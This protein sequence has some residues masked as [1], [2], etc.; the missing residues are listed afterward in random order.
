MRVL[1]VEDDPKISSFLLKGL[2]EDRHVV[3]HAMD[4]VSAEERAELEAFDAIVLDLILPGRDGWQVCR[5]LRAAGVLTPI[6]M[7]T[8]R[9]AVADRVLGL[10]A[11]ADDYLVKPFAFEE[12]VARLRALERRG[13]SRVRPNLLQEGPL[14][15]DLE[16]HQ[17]RLEGRLLDLTATEYRLL[18][19]LTR[20]AGTIVSREQL[21]D[22]VWGDEYDPFSNLAD[23][24]VSYLRRKLG[25]PLIHT[26]R[27]LGYMLK[28]RPNGES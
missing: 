17:A 28:A 4:G 7:L 19:C 27:G 10:D 26:V 23:V 12:L 8:A 5:N 9:D 20:R 6:L 21:A 13:A 14:E 22:H 15:I 16:G 24:Y 2:R 3:V 1:L 18:E 11:G 25:R